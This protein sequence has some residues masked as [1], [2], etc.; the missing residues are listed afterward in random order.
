[1]TRLD[2]TPGE[3]GSSLA[4]VSKHLVASLNLPVS[5]RAMPRRLLVAAD[6]GA[7]RKTVNAASGAELSRRE[8]EKSWRSRLSFDASRRHAR[9]CRVTSARGTRG[10]IVAK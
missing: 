9:Y 8:L 4:A 1:M 6:S 2:H 5:A 3:S 10:S 7:S